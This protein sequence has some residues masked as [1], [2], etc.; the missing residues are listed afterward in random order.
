MAGDIASDGP[1][2]DQG[3][4]RTAADR[5]L[6]LVR[7]GTVVG[8]PAR[9]LFGQVM[10]LVAFTVGFTALG[11]YLGRNL[12]GGT[13]ILFF[14]V[15]FACI[16]G[17]Q[18]ATARGRDQLAVGLLF[19][20]GLALGLAVAPVINVY[21]KA[22]PSALWQA[23]GAT[24]ATV[25]GLGAIGYATRRD[26]SS[27][28]RFLFWALVALIVFGVVLIFVNIPHANIVYAVL[29]ILIFG[30]YTIFDFNRLRQGNMSDP[31]PIA[32]SIFLDIFNIF[33]FFLELFGSER[34]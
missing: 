8:S 24:A 17:L 26:L 28:A 16:F 31:V 34:N 22:D 25:A 32:A 9:S 14:I 23:A 3:S 30:G 2:T 13:G 33:L 5:G 4:T 12:T 29:G 11:A 1:P 6:T 21:A 7:P 20:L 27:W 10:G 18:F 15:G 19:G